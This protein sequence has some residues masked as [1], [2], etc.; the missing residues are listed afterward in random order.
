MEHSGIVKTTAVKDHD[1]AA[2]NEALKA[3]GGEH[4]NTTTNLV[5]TEKGPKDPTVPEGQ[6]PDNV[7]EDHGTSTETTAP[8]SGNPPTQDTRVPETQ[9]ADSGNVYISTS[10]EASNPITAPIDSTH[11][12]L[13]L[14]VDHEDRAVE[15]FEAATTLAVQELARTSH[16][17]IASYGQRLATL[18]RS[19][20]GQQYQVSVR[21]HTELDAEQEALLNQVDGRI[22][23][24]NI[25]PR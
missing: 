15:N 6:T 7:G 3:P 23:T 24:G 20:N 18:S 10:P 13:Y 4:A 8:V 17:V 16:V 2:E 14:E 5:G 21:R 25:A 22:L 19:R 9:V 12:E 11:P 1:N